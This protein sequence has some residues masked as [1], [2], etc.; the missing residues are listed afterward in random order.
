[1]K[2]ILISLLIIPQLIFAQHKSIWN[3]VDIKTRTS[4]QW[5]DVQTNQKE[6]NIEVLNEVLNQVKINGNAILTMPHPIGGEL[7][8]NV[9]SS[10]LLSKE[11]Q[12]KYPEIQTLRGQS[13]NGERIRMN[14]NALGLSA[15][16]FSEEGT[17]FIA[18]STKESKLYISYFE[19]DDHCSSDDYRF[20]CQ[21]AE[22]PAEK[23]HKSSKELVSSTMF[24]KRTIGDEYKKYRLALIV[25]ANYTNNRANGDVNAAFNEIISIVDI[26]TGIFESQVGITF[27][28][29]TDEETIF[30]ESNSGPYGD[31]P[32]NINILRGEDNDRIR[33][34][35]YLDDETNLGF[36]NYDVGHVI[37]SGFDGG[38][39]STGQVC[40]NLKGGGMS[41]FPRG[42]SV[43]YF[44]IRTFTH[45]LGH[46]FGAGHT[47]SASCGDHPTGSAFE[48][49]SGH[50]IMSYADICGNHNNIPDGTQPYFHAISVEQ[51]IAFTSENSGK[52]CFT[53]IAITNAPPSVTIPESGFNIP[54]NT[55][56]VLQG[57]ASDQDNDTLIYNWEQFDLATES[58]DLDKPVD[59]N[60]PDLL[61]KEEFVEQGI[62]A[63]Y[64]AGPDASE[65]EINAAYQLYLEQYND[66]FGPVFSFRGDG[67]LFRNFVPT[68][69]SKRYFPSL[70]LILSG[71][72]SP[73]E[74][75]PFTS[76]D[77]NFVFSARDGKGGLSNDIL[78]FSS[79]TEAG[80]FVVTTEFSNP[81]YNGFSSIT[82]LWD[83]ANTTAPPINCQNVDILYSINGGE[84]FDIVLKEGILNDGSEVI[85]LP[86]IETNQARVMVKASDNIFFNVNDRNFKIEAVNVVAPRAATDLIVS[87]VDVNE[88]KLSWADNSDVEDGF[89]IE[90]RS[91]G[92]TDFLKIGQTVFNVNNFNDDKLEAGRTYFYR[93]AAFNAAG[94]TDFTNVVSVTIDGL[95]DP[96]LT[97]I[98]TEELMLL[99]PNPAKNVVYLSQSLEKQVIGY[100]IYDL[101][102]NK[103]IR[104]KVDASDGTT[105]IDVTL[106]STGLYLVKL[107]TLDRSFVRKLCKE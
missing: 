7:I 25:K 47:Y 107:V 27:E 8:F 64:G 63:L 26:A 11:I 66:L 43:D 10:N 46:Q 1:M 39:A 74:V 92:D 59:E 79:T 6:L 77:L 22:N 72:A 102:G 104:E 38:I 55:P 69:S 12:K 50:T 76:R 19:M 36:D 65:D 52:K 49:G 31:R 23:T 41:A 42:R 73:M 93:V 9:E 18:P 24:N 57:Q 62:A 61:S 103:I 20:Q 48:I 75:L 88:I 78:S 29:V 101:I 56:F 58:E 32:I 100:T 81:S 96:P 94:A 17:I 30:T 2:V 28:I 70:D 80:P 82:L 5:S 3:S 14:V 21:T 85:E 68:S 60:A 67:P 95:V 44:A 89:I 54:I 33:A 4:N 53:S 97:P 34:I 105:S 37:A 87:K 35:T 99:Y 86:N 91:D 13:A 40:N 84:T 15:I 90:R 16:I 45:E 71:N 83:V 51:M 106:L 98:D